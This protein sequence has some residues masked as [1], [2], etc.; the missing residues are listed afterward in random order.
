MQNHILKWYFMYSTILTL[1]SK[2]RPQLRLFLQL[3]A[4]KRRV[5]NPCSKA[6]ALSGQEGCCPYQ[7]PLL[8]RRGTHIVL[9]SSKRANEKKTKINHYFYVAA[10][11][12]VPRVEN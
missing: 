2:L 1:N 10:S 4:Y 6:M 11:N 7:F 3:R 9:I 8:Y 12:L 5:A